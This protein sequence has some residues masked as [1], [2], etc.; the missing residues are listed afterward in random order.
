VAQATV[1]CH[2]QSQE[3][4]KKAITQAINSGQK[5][6]GTIMLNPHPCADEIK[7]RPEAE[8]LLVTGDSGAEVTK[9]GLHWL[10]EGA[11]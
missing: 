3:K 5:V 11:N 9:K 10:T 1:A 2:S 7:R 8:V 6:L 4:F